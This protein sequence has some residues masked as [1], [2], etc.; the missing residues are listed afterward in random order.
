MALKGSC[1]TL[2][3]TKIHRPEIF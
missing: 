1:C 3:R 2:C